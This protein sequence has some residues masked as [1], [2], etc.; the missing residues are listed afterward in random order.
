MVDSVAVASAR[1]LCVN[2]FP[3][4]MGI[5]P[6]PEIDCNQKTTME[7][8]DPRQDPPMLEPAAGSLRLG[9]FVRAVG[10][11]VRSGVGLLFWLVIGTAALAAS[12]VALTAIWWFLSL[13]FEAVGIGRVE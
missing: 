8:Q 6:L 1:Q 12:A 2:L 4:L 9:N 11:L 13:V 5:I 3:N 7:Q 10:D